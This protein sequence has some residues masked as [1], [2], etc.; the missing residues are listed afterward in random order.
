[1][2]RTRP[3]WPYSND[4][5]LYSTAFLD[6]RAGPQLLSLPAVSG[7]YVN[8]QLFDM[9]TNT[10]ADVGVL[11]DGGHRWYLRLRRSRLARHPPERCT[12]ASTSLRQMHGC[13]DGPW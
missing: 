4:D 12:S 6:L 8:F 11:T 7:R 2:V 9:Y 10:I 13:S 1:M 3:R 5:T